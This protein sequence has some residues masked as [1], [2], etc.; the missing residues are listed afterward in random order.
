[1]KKPDE[2]RNRWRTSKL[3]RDQIAAFFELTQSESATWDDLIEGL[4]YP[5]LIA[6][7]AVVRLHKL[8]KVPLDEV[9]PTREG[10]GGFVY[11]SGFWRN[12]LRT[13]QIL[14]SARIVQK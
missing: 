11:D 1:M 4:A 12:L 3:H 9:A 2:L 10:G 8:L 14:S 5:G 7:D 6:E 13:R